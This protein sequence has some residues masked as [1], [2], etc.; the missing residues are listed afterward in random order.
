MC[1]RVLGTPNEDSWP[2]VSSLQDW[3]DDFPR[4]PTLF[5][6]NL[7]GNLSEEGVNLIEVVLCYLI[8]F[9]MFD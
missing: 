6:G 4:W 3:N 1:I 7:V 2:G 9:V 5:L 8:L